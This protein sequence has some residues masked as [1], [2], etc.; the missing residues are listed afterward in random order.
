LLVKVTG[1]EYLVI[2]TLGLAMGLALDTGIIPNREKGQTSVGR[3]ASPLLGDTAGALLLISSAVKG[4]VGGAVSSLRASLVLELTRS[5]ALTSQGIHG[6]GAEHLG[7]LALRLALVVALDPVV[8]PRD[9][10]RCAGVLQQ[11]ALAVHMTVADRVLG[12]AVHGAVAWAGA[13]RPGVLDGVAGP[14]AWAAQRVRGAW[15]EHLVRTTR[16]VGGQGV[17]DD[18]VGVGGGR[19]R[20]KGEEDVKEESN[21][22]IH[23]LNI[24]FLS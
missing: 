24:E 15:A 19:G 6:T 1:A 10:V 4:A 7:R 14:R 3:G 2:S 11:A 21:E 13:L 8:S 20:N 16:G 22:E 12:P 5:C 23:L 18:L 17:A 9:E